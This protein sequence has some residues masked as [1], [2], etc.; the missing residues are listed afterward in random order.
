M[1]RESQ[2]WMH[3]LPGKNKTESRNGIISGQNINM[4]G[5]DE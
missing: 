1:F 5:P 3:L 4:I 2:G